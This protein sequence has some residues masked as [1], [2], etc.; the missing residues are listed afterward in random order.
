VA[1]FALS[2]RLLALGCFR[3]CSHRSGE[4]N[5]FTFKKW[6]PDLRLNT[7]AIVNNVI[8]NSGSYFQAASCIMQHLFFVYCTTVIAMVAIKRGILTF[9][10]Q[11]L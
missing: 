6:P 5:P 3:M 2:F 11:G 4:K 8:G 7:P 10:L 9:S 1:V